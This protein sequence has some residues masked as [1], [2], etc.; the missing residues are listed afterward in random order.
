M[1]NMMKWLPGWYASR[2]H[3]VQADKA[4]GLEGRQQAQ[5]VCGAWVYGKAPTEWAQRYVDR[6]VPHCKRCQKKLA[7]A[8][9]TLNQ[10]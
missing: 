4:P 8:E 5:A 10:K 9:S 7:D 3:A 6:G 1:N 2:L